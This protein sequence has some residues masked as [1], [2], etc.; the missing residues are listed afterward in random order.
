MKNIFTL[1]FCLFI[2]SIIAQSPSINVK[3]QDVCGNPFTENAEVKLFYINNADTIVVQTLSGNNV[4]FDN[5]NTTTN[6]EVK[7]TTSSTSNS[8]QT[9]KDVYVMRQNILGILNV[10]NAFKFAAD[11]NG[12]GGISTLDLVLFLRKMIGI[13]TGSAF[14]EDWFF[15]E[16]NNL[17]SG[18]NTNILNHS[19]VGQLSS[20][21]KSI[22]F[23][24]YRFG[25]PFKTLP[26]SCLPCP[27]D[28]NSISKILV[29][30]LFLT[31]GVSQIV[32][33]PILYDVK[34]I[35]YKLSLKYKDAI[36][37]NISVGNTG[38]YNHIAN[39]NIINMANLY[40]N[41]DT[42]D[43][44]T[45]KSANYIQFLVTPL[46]TG[47]LI[48]MVSLDPNFENE[49]Y[50]KLGDC[51]KKYKNIELKNNNLDDC[52]IVWPQD[53]KIKDCNLLTK[54]GR[55]SVDEKC[56]DIFN[57]TYSDSEIEPCKKI[58]RTWSVL[59]ILT[60]EIF[61]HIQVIEIDPTFTF[62]CKEVTVIIVDGN[63][64]LWAADLCNNLPNNTY[65]FRKDKIEEF[66]LIPLEGPLTFEKYVYNI[67]NNQSCIATI[68]KQINIVG[69]CDILWPKDITI[70]RCEDKDITGQPDVENCNQFVTF[71]YTDIEI[72]PCQ[73]ILRTWL[74]LNTIT[75]KVFEHVQTITIDTSLINVCKEVSV[76]I[77]LG[78]TTVNI[79]ELV[80][81][82]SSHIFSFN[83]NYANDT[84]IVLGFSEPQIIYKNIYDLTDGTFCIA[85]IVK[86]LCAE[87]K[88]L[89]LIY[90]K[91][92]GNEYIVY[93][94]DFDN[95]NSD[96]CL[97]EVSNFKI[98]LQGQNSYSDYITL[99]EEGRK[100][101][102]EL[103][104]L[105]YTINGISK[106][107]G[108]VK[109]YF[110]ENGVPIF[111]LTCY[112][113]ILEKGV[114]FS[115]AISSS[116]FQNVY[117]IQ[118]G[119]SVKN[120]KIVS[121]QKVALT[122]MLYNLQPNTLKIVWVPLSAQPL[123]LSV[124]DTLFTIKIMPAI[125]GR[126][127]DFLAL[128]QNVLV[129]EAT[130]DSFNS[131]YIDLVFKFLQ[132]FPNKTDEINKQF[133]ASIYPN[134]NNGSELNI[135]SN[136]QGEATISI[137]DTNNRLCTNEKVNFENGHSTINLNKKLP[138]GIY[139]IRISN[140]NGFVVKKLI[141]VD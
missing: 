50:Y 79:H 73:K 115:I 121:I 131:Q 96:N 22:I 119:F 4:T 63:L 113:D 32:K 48:D 23:N 33:L 85:K 51:L 99:Q 36:V 13:N 43:V 98:S 77:I 89:P 71:S 7:V 25:E 130:T 54:T 18:L 90:V 123:S 62:E 5:L 110:I 103:F 109:V 9:I 46:K 116:T 56:K 20:G 117:G 141:V 34:D 135:K 59:N 31:V 127:S 17:N 139:A 106:Y 67:T 65:S 100:G 140:Q 134:P 45:F 137:F 41:V 105:S 16:E 30:D 83:R 28:P 44:Q 128:D 19:D 92:T 60:A 124:V 126:V 125:N 72:L 118:A 35:G 12:N 133:S 81:A 101:T 1:L 6:Y 91:T 64:Q 129:P 40:L 94:K 88:V 10:D 39:E 93:A 122:E 21:F 82:G 78:G 2:S 38:Q 68:N 120:A 102:F 136:M 95:G 69:E 111:E 26:Q 86:I 42:N 76:L 37:E 61:L 87:I 24:A 132:R 70:K 15:I 66:I 107:Y 75:L 84:S 74:G 52:S 58:L 114:P 108:D 27:A 29:P 53:I 55:P 49:I 104:S 57:F 97:G 8:K 47:K 3:V 112:D 138:N 80:E 14:K 11:Y